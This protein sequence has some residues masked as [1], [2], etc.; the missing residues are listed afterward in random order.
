VQIASSADVGPFCATFT[1][2]VNARVWIEST[3]GDSGTDFLAMC[4]YAVKDDLSPHIWDPCGT[5]SVLGPTVE[6]QIT[7]LRN[8]FSSTVVGLELNVFAE[9]FFMFQEFMNGIF[10]QFFIISN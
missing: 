2:L 8:E 10:N 4:S 9:L 6:S 7:R 5:L 3:P 1:A